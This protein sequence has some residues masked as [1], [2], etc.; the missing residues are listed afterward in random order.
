MDISRFPPPA[1]LASWGKTAQGAK[2]SRVQEGHRRCRPRR[3]PTWPECWAQPLSASKIDTFRGER[4]LCIVRRFGKN[5]AIVAIGRSLMV[6]VWHLPSD[7]E[8][9]FHDLGSDFYDNWLGPE[10]IRRTNVPG[11]TP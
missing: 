3:P 8:A 1:H 10:R 5:M 2:E 9:R 11:G 7:S 4:Y 6:I